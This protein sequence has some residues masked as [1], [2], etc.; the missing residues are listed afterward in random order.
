MRFFMTIPEAVLLLIQAGS[1]ST[2]IYF[3][4]G[5]AWFKAGEAGRAILAFRQAEKLS[6]RDPDVRANLQFA[7]G[8]RSLKCPYCGAL[9]VIAESSE[10]V[11]EQD[12]N[13]AFA[14]CCREEDLHEQ[15][16]VKCTTCGAETTLAPSGSQGTRRPFSNFVTDAGCA[17]SVI[18]Q[19]V[20]NAAGSETRIR[21]PGGWPIL[22][23]STSNQ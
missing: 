14:D 3:N 21:A 7:P 1:I 22:V 16:T 19:S 8:T 13:T 20:V 18:R 11:E 6:P 10:R 15:I 17:P 2:P 9:N 12:F 5:N 4:L 23:S